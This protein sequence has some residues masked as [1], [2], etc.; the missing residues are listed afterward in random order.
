VP[1]GVG[2]QDGTTTFLLDLLQ[3]GSEVIGNDCSD[4]H[5]VAIAIAIVI[6]ASTASKL[7]HFLFTVP[8]IRRVFFGV[9]V[10]EPDSPAAGNMRR[11][12]GVILVDRKPLLDFVAEGAVIH[13]K[14]NKRRLCLCP[15][16]NSRLI[17]S[18]IFVFRIINC[19]IV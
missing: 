11:F 10:N 19:L 13:R 1:R 3:I 17:F 18:S 7:G 14:Y 15:I 8:H 16:S 4:I 6:V 9:V 5:C 2:F 12:G